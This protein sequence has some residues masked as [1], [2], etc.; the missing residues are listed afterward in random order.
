[1]RRHNEDGSVL[2]GCLLAPHCDPVETPKQ[3]E[4]SHDPAYQCLR[5]TTTKHHHTGLLDQNRTQH[6]AVKQASQ[7]TAYGVTL[8]S[9]QTLQRASLISKCHKISWHE[10]RLNFDHSHRIIQGFS[11]TDFIFPKPTNIKHN[12]CRYLTPIFIQ[13]R[14][15][16]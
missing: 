10:P 11:C 12:L 13:I 14:E 5:I 2:S 16:M 1:M 3:E 4:Q 8:D 7:I 15:Q 9:T 6:N